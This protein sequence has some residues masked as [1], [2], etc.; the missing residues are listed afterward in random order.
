MSL[1]WKKNYPM[2]KVQRLLNKGVENMNRTNSTITKRVIALLLTLLIA[3]NGI[4]GQVFA[5][6]P[7]DQTQEEYTIDV[8]DK[9]GNPVQG[10][11][12][13]CDMTIIET[14]P[15]SE[16][17]SETHES[18]E[19]Q[20]GEDGICAIDLEQILTGGQEGSTRFILMKLVVFA[21]GYEVETINNIRITLANAKDR[22]VVSLAYGKDT[23]TAAAG[24]GGN[25]LLNDEDV[26]SIQIERNS[27]V[28]IVVTPDEGYQI[29][30]VTVDGVSQT[31]DDP[32]TFSTDV[33]VTG[34]MVV[35]AVFV[36]TYTV[37]FR[38]DNTKGT[39]E[40]QPASLGGT[41]GAEELTVK[42]GTE[43][44][45]TATPDELYRVARVVLKKGDTIIADEPYEENIYTNANPYRRT[46]M[47]DADYE[48]EVTFAYRVQKVTAETPEHGT[49]QISEE[50]VE[51][52]GR[53]TV[54][55][56]PEQNY[57]IKEIRI[58]DVVMQE[59]ECENG[60]EAEDGTLRFDLVQICEDK[61]IQV[62]FEADETVAFENGVTF[63]SADAI[64]KEGTNRY[65]FAKDAKVIFRAADGL[66]IRITDDK[67]RE[68]KWNS[69]TKSIE[70]TETT[71]IKRI[72]VREAGFFSFFYKWTDVTLPDGELDILVDKEAPSLNMVPDTANEYG[73]Y[74]AD[75]SVQI[76]AEEAES[77][78]E[79]NAALNGYSG[80][81][82]VEY[83]VTCDGTIT[84]GKGYTDGDTTDNGILYEYVSGET[85]ISEV[86]KRV[87]VMADR[88]NSDNVVLHVAVTDRAGNTGEE[89]LPLK[90][91]TTVP[92]FSYTMTGTKDAAAMEGYYNT[93]RTAVITYID[94]ADSFDKALAYNGIKI[95]ARDVDGNEMP[96]NAE[97]LNP[98]WQENG[99][100]H[101]LTLTFS[102]DANYEWSISYTNKAGSEAA[103]GT[104]TG[105]D[106]QV[107]TVDKNAP[108]GT[109]SVNEKGWS[110]LLQ[111]LTFGI[112]R[113]TAT[114]VVAE[115]TDTTSPLYDVLYYKS[116]SEEVLGKAELEELYAQ[117]SFTQDAVTVEED[118]AFA[119]YARI[120]DYAG[121]TVYVGTNG[122]VVDMT[123][124]LISVT[125]DRPNEYGYYKSDVTVKVNVNELN[126][127]EIKDYSGIKRVDYTVSMQKDGSR[128]ITQQ[129]NLYT[130]DN[131]AP[132]KDQL[133]QMVDEEFVVSK[134]LNN[135]DDV[136]VTITAEDNAGNRETRTVPVNINATAPKVQ[137][138]IDGIA[139]QVSEGRGYYNTTRT[140]VIT[141]EDRSS[142]FDPAAATAGIEIQ[143]EDRNG[144]AI[145]LDKAAMLSDWK[146]DGDIHTAN[147]TFTED[148]YYTWS[149]H[150][151]NKAGL[152]NGAITVRGENPYVFAIDRDA[153]DG[154]IT[155]QKTTWN[156]LLKVL[157]FGL[158]SNQKVRVKMTAE[159]VVSPCVIEYYKT[160]DAK[161]KTAAELD[162]LYNAG[163]FAA[164]PKAGFEVS[165]E[166]FVIYERVT[167]YAGNYRYI[168]SDGFIVDTTGCGITLIPSE[169]NG[170]Y[171]KGNAA[172]GLYNRKS[173]VEVQV[174]V[175]DLGAYSGIRT[176][177][178][179]IEKDGVKTQSGN[180]FT[181]AKTNPA[182]KDLVSDWKG[183]ITVDKAKNNSCNVT[184]YVKTCDNAGNETVQ[185]VKLDIDNTAPQIQVTYQNKTKPDA[186]AGYFKARTATVVIT[187]RSHHFD[188]DAATKG[189]AITAKDAKGAAVENAYTI[190]G[191][192]T[193]ENK[194][195]PDAST[196]TAVI[197]YKKDANYTL[198]IS[199]KDLAGNKN[200]TVSTNGQKSPYK[201]TVDKTAPTGSVQAVSAEGRTAEWSGL[202][203]VLTYGFCSNREIT[204]SCTKE[205]LTSPIKSV[206]YYIDKVENTAQNKA[207]GVK[208]LTRKELDRVTGWQ[209]FRELKL[210]DNVQ[211]VVY[212]RIR[213]KAGNYTYLSTDG[214]MIDKQNPLVEYIA[215]EVSVDPVQ[216]V[217]EIYRD[218]V[219]VD[220]SVSDPVTGGTCSG[221]GRISYQIYNR[222][223]NG[224]QPTQ[225]GDL[226]VQDAN[227]QTAE[228]L[229]RK[230]SGSITVDSTL[231]N[232][233]DVLIVITAWDNAGNSVQAEQTIKVDKTAPKIRVRYDNN[234]AVNGT[235]FGGDRHAYVSITERNFDPAAVQIST[236]NTNG[237]LPEISDWSRQDGSGNEDDTVWTAVITYQTDGDYTFGIHYTDMAGNPADGVEYAEGTA[238]PEA[239]TIDKTVPE[240]S[241]SYDNRDARNGN[242]YNAARTATITVTE[243]NF[244]ADLVEV[245]VTATRD[246]AE[247][248]RPSVSGW[249][250]DGDRH[251]ATITY[252]GDALYTFQIAVH[253][254]VG[255]EAE[256]YPEESFYIDTT[257]PEL[258]LQNITDQAAYNGD[259]MPVVT[260]SDANYDPENLTVQLTGANHGTVTPEG[261]YTHT[262]DGGTFTFRNFANTKE[263]DDI[264]TL[265]ASLTDRAGNTTTKEVTFSVNRFGSTYE[266]GDA[267][268]RFNS[269]YV[270]DA[271]DVVITE[272]NANALK[273]IRLTL[274]KNNQTIV[275]TEG[276]D[277]RMDVTGGNG[278]WYRYVYTIFKKNF[279]DDG[280]Y[281]LNIHSEDGAGNVA[282]NTLDTKGAELRFGVDKT[283]PN[284]VLLNLESHKTYAVDQMTAEVSASDNLLLKTVAVYL[285]DYSQPYRTWNEKEVAEMTAGNQPYTFDIS[286]DSIHAHNVKVVTTDAAGNEQVAEAKGF[287]VTTN[288]W[289]RYYT[290]KGLF[291]GTIGGVIGLA[292]FIVFLVSLKRRRREGSR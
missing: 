211:G 243:H 83:W 242:Y 34:D 111:K 116:D 104:G 100:I 282:E 172:Y 231:N 92:E 192:K 223:V 173:K 11:S 6:N 279:E 213:D 180:L 143:A 235:Y 49:I 244:N 140:A 137:V 38:Y 190:S 200:A 108:Q 131:A 236:T 252:S 52:G 227:K 221:I 247:A 142:T 199:Y 248:A 269:S 261:A 174:N 76:R 281:R 161:A 265:Q 284:I 146:S 27:N 229:V 147:V 198:S 95:L 182:K 32:D 149:F 125:L 67:N 50:N 203:S 290:N 148:G 164:Y 255:N 286:G 8:Q 204:I 7:G 135:A 45:V 42:S 291:F 220:L 113:N 139:G 273:N 75:V 39:L 202:R 98:V 276:T 87:V 106:L 159:D 177:D 162:T 254:M 178:Y 272:V 123:K 186:S 158:Y 141:I 264:Y 58:N 64:R 5:G 118:E 256:R 228:E 232:S 99:D 210:T 187:E 160:S 60:Q 215:P 280:A 136:E 57:H 22:R 20:T 73:Y 134:D 157:T 82:T 193:I 103:E 214:L 122:I 126:A 102:R 167:D 30:S 81:D 14:V 270:R 130:F 88:N 2:Q 262:Q 33:T 16:M 86:E 90:I 77:R 275:L 18:T 267:A 249:Q 53:S 206:D 241:V 153:P 59:T 36:K 85:I 107:F 197:T 121:N 233:N 37:T 263:N 152:S 224:Q 61:R 89:Q 196:H 48:L 144:K 35:Q 271:E 110:D 181:Y 41:I 26:D 120:T 217:N 56:K 93:D 207:T 151:E 222:A 209:S 127:E 239:F 237:V 71:V 191:W 74:N 246:G 47:T 138:A 94:R 258:E 208:P 277:Y 156:K 289:I 21:E 25:I 24:E 79:T 3:V 188:P 115:G 283:A 12:V 155:I 245:R 189:I 205:D 15:G 132:T 54:T 171:S 10:A 29:L 68:I 292:A 170:F 218:D 31:I 78:D 4:P 176:V 259:V 114:S 63:N 212:V 40:T 183:K 287:F 169:S 51:Y 128:V 17:Q 163:K 184:V 133:V 9:N 23:V 266:F 105:E 225:S 238:A 119:V 19:L 165:D 145:E 150:Y 216:P 185:S 253:D 129:G 257:A 55:M 66:E 234:Q 1:C 91:N 179:W 154:T 285:D 69:G 46:I 201:F 260:G 43:I 101:I 72:R 84:Q 44:R 117:G 13:S 250:Q 62:V 219:K 240:V 278:K 124:S 194:S 97:Y 288:L 268:K 166:Q 70:L 96:M 251:T 112:Y 175:Q 109:I 28:H 226:Y 65:I 195:N 168:S 80:I 230:W 274:F